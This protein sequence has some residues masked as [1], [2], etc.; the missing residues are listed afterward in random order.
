MTVRT[1]FTL[2]SWLHN[3]PDIFQNFPDNP[4]KFRIIQTF[5]MSFIKLP[6]NIKHFRVQRAKTFRTRKNFP[7]SNAT[8]LPTYFCLLGLI[9]GQK[10]NNWSKSR[11]RSKPSNKPTH[12]SRPLATCIPSRLRQIHYRAAVSLIQ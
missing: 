2:S 5:S 1:V 9:I 4:E 10:P 8:T 12:V 11:I 3:F 7:G 6:V